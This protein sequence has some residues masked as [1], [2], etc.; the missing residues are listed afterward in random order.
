MRVQRDMNPSRSSV[1]QRTS[2]AVRNLKGH[3][4]Y[5]QRRQ[6]CEVAEFMKNVADPLRN[7]NGMF[8]KTKGLLV[9]H[10]MGSGKTVTSLWVAK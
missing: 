4:E 5:E 9:A 7:K 8:S 10:G 1:E 3:A 2:A 6:Q